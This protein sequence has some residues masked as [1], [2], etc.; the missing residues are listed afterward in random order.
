MSDVSL[1]SIRLLNRKQVAEA[2]GRAPDTLDSWVRK[3]VFP[4]PLQAAPGAP[5]QW[6]FTVVMAWLEKRSRSRYVPP[7]PRGKLQNQN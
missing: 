5:K 6:R 2:L 3:G 1:D 4:A 7:T